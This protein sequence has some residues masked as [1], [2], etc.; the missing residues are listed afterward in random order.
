MTAPVG[1]YESSAGAA[2]IDP[3]HDQPLQR[4]PQVPSHCGFWPIFLQC[5][6]SAL[7]VSPVDWTQC[8]CTEANSSNCLLE[9]K[10]VTAVCLCSGIFC[11]V[12]QRQTAVTASLK[13]SSYFCLNLLWPRLSFSKPN[14]SNVLLN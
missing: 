14:S 7:V 6:R 2:D 10:A 1:L 12:V 8:C 9:K 3:V 11:R 4:L 5:L 13:M